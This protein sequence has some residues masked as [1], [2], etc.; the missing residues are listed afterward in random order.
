MIIC[1]FE[2]RGIGSMAKDKSGLVHIYYGDGKGKTTAAFGLALRCAGRGN[3]VVITQFLKSGTSGELKA[4]AGVPGI[5]IISGKPV[6]K[7]T[8]QMDS[9]EL[10][11]TAEQ[12][13][14]ALCEAIEQSKD[15]RL[16]VL[17]EVIDA[18]QSGLVSKQALCRFLDEKPDGLEVV[19]TGHSLP[20][21]LTR[22]ADYITRMCKEKHPYDEGL[23]ARAD[24][25]F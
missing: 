19:L 12:C 5:H 23:T 3:K 13:G 25:E 1:I 10:A 11:R 20:A 21:E 15:A 16:L 9:Q 22:R 8:F 7:F 18:Y 4:V 2:M 17:D 14:E 24:I 6:G